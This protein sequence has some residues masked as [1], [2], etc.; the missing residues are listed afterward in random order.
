MRVCRRAQEAPVA[1]ARWLCQS[2]CSEPATYFF[3]G[4]V[5]VHGRVYT[6]GFTVTDGS[7]N[8]TAS[9]LVV[10]VD[11]DQGK[12]VAVDDGEAYRVEP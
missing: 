12:G 11:H 1:I 9:T 8:A 10:T 4:I 6:V 2:S 5:T 7:G 3:A